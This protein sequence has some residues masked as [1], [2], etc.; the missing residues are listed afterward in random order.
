MA[1]QR[2]GEQAPKGKSPEKDVPTFRQLARGWLGVE[3]S[4]KGVLKVRRWRGGWWVWEEKTGRYRKAEKEEVLA[5]ISGRYPA[6]APKVVGGVGEMAGWM[7]LVLEEE[8]PCW[9]GGKGW[10]A[11]EC[12]PLENGVLN[13]GSWCERGVIELEPATPAWFCGH[14]AEYG[15]EAG[16]KCERWMRFLG[17]VWGDDEEQKALLQE[18]FGYCLT[19][20]TRAEK[21]LLMQGP[22]GSGKSTTLDVL[23]AVVGQSACA[24]TTFHG[25]CDKFGME[26]LVGKKVVTI[27]DARVGTQNA[28]EVGLERVLQS[29]GQDSQEIRRMYEKT[30]GNVRIGARFV[31]ACNELPELAD[32]SGAIKRRL[33]TL[34][35]PRGFGEKADPDLKKE[36]VGEAAGVLNWA[37]EGLRRLRG[38]GMKFVQPQGSEWLVREVEGQGNPVA[39]FAREAMMEAANGAESKLAVT[40][41]YQEWCRKENKWPLVEALMARGL[42]ACWPTVESVRPR[43]ANGEREYRWQGVRFVEGWEWARDQDSSPSYGGSEES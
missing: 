18:W 36:L 21:F 28:V 2:V 39:L 7:S 24:S 19:T 3:G 16:A 43:L 31:V 8:M 20:D 25:L 6:L 33:L 34:E 17:E 4:H 5:G 9:V 29:V 13:V 35:Y 32:A 27:R 41:A 42:K 22:P 15:Y 40:R 10:D 30:Q 11:R 23:Q 37:L 38:R 12:L 14:S 26:P 1:Q